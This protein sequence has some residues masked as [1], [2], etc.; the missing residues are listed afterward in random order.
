MKKQLLVPFALVA[1]VLPTANCSCTDS[2]AAAGITVDGDVTTDAATAC[3]S[4]AT[5]QA[6][7]ACAANAFL[8]LSDTSGVQFDNDDFESRTLWNNLPVELKPRAGLQLSALS[9]DSLAAALD[10]IRLAMAED[11]KDT[12]TG[13]L[14]ADDLLAES[15]SGYG[16][17]L[18]S[19]AT[20][21]EPTADGSFALMFGGHHMGYNFTYTGSGISFTPQHLGCEPKDD[22]TLDGATYAPMAPKGDA[23]FSVYDALSS[24]EQTTAYLSGQSFSDVVVAP[25]LDYGKG[26]GRTSPDAYPTG[27]SRTGLL[28]SEMSADTQALVV[29]VIEAWAAQACW[30]TTPP[31]RRLPTRTSPGAGARRALIAI[32]MARISGLMVRACGS[33]WRCKTALSTP[34]KHTI[35]RSFATRPSTTAVTSEAARCGSAPRSARVGTRC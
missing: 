8:A 25:D 28:V 5:A 32:K 27:S 33:N 12:A 20:F 19:I 29:A 21:G 22:F 31:P 3:A 4:E 35:T 1:A 26:S 24:D 13:V 7:V 9:T 2:S 14:R 10:V 16:S 11:G 15:A 17:G 23:F 30:P 18:Y 34:T 6:R